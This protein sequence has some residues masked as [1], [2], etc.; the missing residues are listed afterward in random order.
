MRS[1]SLQ[2]SAVEISRLD[3]ACQGETVQRGVPIS[4]DLDA[5][6]RRRIDPASIDKPLGEPID[7]GKI[8]LFRKN[9]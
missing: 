7:A 3:P 5:F 1:G 6:G 8:T 4:C 9:S 2:N